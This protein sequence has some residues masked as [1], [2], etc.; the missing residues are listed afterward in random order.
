M[1]KRLRFAISL[2][3]FKATSIT[4]ALKILLLKRG[5][6]ITATIA[7]SWHPIGGIGD[8]IPFSRS[9]LE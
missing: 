9:F 2:R 7:V 4:H 5:D 1:S 8:I 6:L 3:E